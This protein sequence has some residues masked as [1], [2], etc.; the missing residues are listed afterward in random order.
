M[1]KASP[2]V[3]LGLR[4]PG[5]RRSQGQ[6]SVEPRRES[7]EQQASGRQAATVC[8]ANKE[9]VGAMCPCQHQAKSCQQHSP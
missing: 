2:S 5:V 3:R 9:T 7:G 6:R 4:V 8:H 1:L